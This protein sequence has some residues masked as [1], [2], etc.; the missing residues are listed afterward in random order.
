MSLHYYKLS[1]SSPNLSTLL[2]FEIS[3]T[4][5]FASSQHLIP[6]TSIESELNQIK[7]QYALDPL[8]WTFPTFK[9]HS[10]ELFEFL[11]QLIESVEEIGKVTKFPFHGNLKKE[12]ISIDKANG[13]I[14]LIEA[15]EIF[16]VLKMHKIGFASPPELS[17]HELTLLDDK[18]DVWSF[19]WLTYEIVTGREPWG[20]HRMNNYFKI[21]REEELKYECGDANII[22]F[23]NKTLMYDPRKRIGWRE[24]K[25]HVICK[26]PPMTMPII[27]SINI[28]LQIAG[29]VDERSL[30]RVSVCS[31]K[32]NIEFVLKKEEIFGKEEHVLRNPNNEIIYSYIIQSYYSMYNLFD[33]SFHIEI[34]AQGFLTN[35][36]ENIDNNFIPDKTQSRFSGSPS[37][38][39]KK[40]GSILN[41]MKSLNNV[42][43]DLNLPILNGNYIISAL[44]KKAG[45]KIVIRIIETDFENP[46]ITS[47]I[48]NAIAEKYFNTI[49][50]EKMLGLIEVRKF[51]FESCDSQINCLVFF[52]DRFEYSFSNLLL[53]K[54]KLT[55]SFKKLVI[56]EIAMLLLNF[57][58][59]NCNILLAAFPY[60]ILIQPQGLVLAFI[61]D[62]FVTSP[63]YENTQN[64]I[65]PSPKLYSDL[66]LLYRK[67]VYSLGI[68]MVE[69]FF[70]EEIDNNIEIILPKIKES[71]EVP[72][73]II[74]LIYKMLQKNIKKRIDLEDVIKELGQTSQNDLK[75]YKE[76]L[77]NP[78]EWGNEIMTHSPKEVEKEKIFN[79]YMI[80]I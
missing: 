52:Y 71:K 15:Q 11:N 26:N 28:N 34:E 14:K 72:P 55:I 25:E 65:D 60:N 47:Y 5:Q 35:K 21:L 17:S 62:M 23:I 45:E 78:I 58:K 22:D 2:S 44:D 3:Q 70:Q 37:S 64:F 51:F 56:K 13:S 27:P 24:M 75:L 41:R 54:G 48:Q 53:L 61:P 16:K 9:S 30:S 69:F 43:S 77:Q 39:N 4:P 57:K 10:K 36:I 59:E 49:M 68:M 40:R 46:N 1:H 18:I 42:D 20:L 74:S 8:P 29:N 33:D 80:S 67:L 38:K 19:G 31:Y 32:N 79:F 7:I 76:M 12:N 63:I 66:N 6:I 50:K 73:E